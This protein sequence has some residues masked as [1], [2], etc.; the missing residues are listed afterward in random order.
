MNYENLKTENEHIVSPYTFRLGDR[1]LERNGW[2]H[3]W[4]GYLPR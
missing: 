4:V 1:I 3:I 2:L